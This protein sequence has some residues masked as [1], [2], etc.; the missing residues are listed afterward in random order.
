[1]NES[2]ARHPLVTLA[3]ICTE[4]ANYHGD[5]W[6]TIE[7]SVRERLQA[8]PDDQRRRINAEIDRILR[9]RAPDACTS[10]Q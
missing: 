6:L 9:Y 5:N 2:A 3:L 7:A 8:L 10:T 4:A 1:M